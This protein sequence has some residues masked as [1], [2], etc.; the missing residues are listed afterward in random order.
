MFFSSCL[1]ILYE[2]KKILI[3]PTLTKKIFNNQYITFN[4][5]KF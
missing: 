1:I 5:N 4:I 2:L 3:L